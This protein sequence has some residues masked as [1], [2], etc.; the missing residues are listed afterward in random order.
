MGQHIGIARFGRFA[1]FH[2]FFG[3]AKTVGAAKSR[4]YPPQN[5]PRQLG[6]R[7]VSGA[8]SPVSAAYWGVGAAPKNVCYEFSEYD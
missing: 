2:G 8:Y 4:T 6:I 7:G 5:E 3:R 1:R